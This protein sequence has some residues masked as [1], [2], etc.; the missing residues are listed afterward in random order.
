MRAEK[1]ARFTRLCPVRSGEQAVAIA[2]SR[3]IFPRADNRFTW[4]QP[5]R[6]GIFRV[7]ILIEVR[8]LPKRQHRIY[9]KEMCAY[10]TVAVKSL[11]QTD[12]L[13]DAKTL[14]NRA[15][16]IREGV[17]RNHVLIEQSRG[18]V[19]SPNEVPSAVCLVVCCNR[20]DEGLG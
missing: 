15:I 19:L 16:I 13:L 10:Q 2:A 7:S 3:S 9:N 6:H 5:W 17:S 11:Q 20:E 4:R 14:G 18:C 8:P 1:P 12:S